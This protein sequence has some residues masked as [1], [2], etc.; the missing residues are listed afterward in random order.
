M[1]KNLP[2]VIGIALPIVFITIIS[3]IVFLPSSF[4]NHAHNIIYTEGDEYSYDYQFR[5]IYKIIDGKI[6]S[7]ANPNI[8]V[9]EG[10]YYD[11][12]LKDAPKIYFYDVEKDASYEIT[13]EQAQKY[14]LV[15]GPSSPDGYN[16]TKKYTHNGIFEIF[17]SSDSGEKYY[18]VSANGNSKQITGIKN[19]QGYYG[20][21]NIIGWIK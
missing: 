13:L 11:R 10:D 14:N 19:T 2:L 3:F 17:G 6:V 16:I 7:V 15:A 5:N 9:V 8:K 1:K 20:Q 18:I 4:V 12:T 21:I